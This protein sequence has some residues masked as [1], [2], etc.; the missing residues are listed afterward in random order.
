MILAA[1]EDDLSYARFQGIWGLGGSFSSVCEYGSADSVGIRRTMTRRDGSVKTKAARRRGVAL[2]WSVLLVTSL[3]LAIP[4]A[5]SA[6]AVKCDGKTPTITGTNGDDVIDGTD[7]PDIIHA[8][9]GNDII[10]GGDG[11]DIICGGA[12]D[13]EIRGGKSGDLLIGGAGN[14]LI[15][16]GSGHDKARGGKGDDTVDGG[17]G[18]DKIKAGGGADNAD[19]GKGDDII[20]GASGNDTLIG[21]PQNDVINGG[22]GD[23]RCAGNTEE[24]CEGKVIDFKVKRFLVNQSVPSADSKDRK[25]E[26]AGT[27]AERPGVV[28]VFISA[29]QNGIEAP[30]VNLY[31][32][33]KNGT[34]TRYKMTGPAIV[35]KKPSP[36]DM[37][38]TFNFEFD[39]TFLKAGMKMYV[40]VDR[41]GKVYELDEGNNRYPNNGFTNI[42]A[43]NV[44]KMKITVVRAQGH[45]MS[46]SEAVALFQKTFQVHP[47][48]DWDIEM[49][50]GK[51]TCQACVGGPSFDNWITLLQEI[52]TLQQSAENP[53]GRMYHAIVPWDY[54]ASIG[55]GGLGYLGYPAAVSIPNDETIAHE[56]GHNLDLYHVAC[57][58]SE[59]QPDPD[60]PYPGGSIGN[61]GRNP[62]TGTTYDPDV[63]NDL[64][65]YCSNEW[66][67]DFSWQEALNHRKLAGY[68]IVG[69]G[70]ATAGNGTVVQ[71]AGNVPADA[72]ASQSYDLTPAAERFDVTI[73]TEIVSA[74]VVD[75]PA[76]PPAPGEYMMVGRDNAGEALVSVSFRAY[77]YDHAPGSRFMFSIEVANEAFVDVVSWN[78]EK[79]GSVVAS[80]Q[81]S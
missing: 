79:A 3:L 14:D 23:D 1:V 76:R 52:A 8:K 72:V 28:R 51:Y 27:V 25:S 46:K 80:R 77:A 66:I 6:A 68:E 39:E 73:P 19:G 31:V 4:A 74:T 22:G 34:I 59:A 18:D 20:K 11:K 7:G 61:W 2:A 24:N 81:A 33:K 17:K 41:K 65:T 15:I 26:R 70:L 55:V 50:S 60:Y 56:T 29:N 12:G 64:M 71:F 30:L 54:G 69:T 58:G 36:G 16:G 49:R 38:S 32:Q 47:V 57:T 35:P 75:T 40:K 53:D 21:G 10:K 37:N 62:Y 63:F 67:S 44:P 9:G 43:M 45:S 13:D 5:S 78:V 48:S 42:M